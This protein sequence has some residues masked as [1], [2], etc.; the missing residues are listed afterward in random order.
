MG[1]K[2]IVTAAVVGAEVTRAQSPAVP[3]TPEEIARAAVDAA[4]AGAAVVHLHA[5]WPDGR[6]SQ[7]GAHFR[8]IID[9][10]RDA[11]CGV[12]VQCST[13]GAVGMSIDER[14]GSLVPGAEM[15]TLN[16]GTMNFG[17]E[18]FVN[19]RPDL[20][21][22][23]G[24][25]REQRLVPECEVYDAG[26]LDTLRWLLEKRHLA[27]PYHVQFVL[28]VPGGM[29]ASERNLRFL[30]E[31]LPEPTHWSV[32]GVGRFQL[33]MA[34][35]ALRLGGHVRVGLED[36]LFVSKGVLAR[37]SDEL[38]SLAVELA[39]RAG[40]IP[41]TPDEARRLLGIT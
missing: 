21:R 24:R 5:R 11:G 12:V 41:A 14:L 16:L 26:M 34:E 32:A 10:I 20:V 7:E 33:P 18:V 30:L 22:V 37:G 27:Q 19:T 8:E 3:Y 39:G 23:A 6:P 28:G 4:R 25:L 38:V 29:S 2:V 1:E 35:L 9:R 31:G 13:G 17:D 15:G 40:R 36:N